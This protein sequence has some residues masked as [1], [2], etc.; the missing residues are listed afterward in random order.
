MVA[1]YVPPHQISDDD[2][3]HATDSVLCSEEQ[4]YLCHF[5][6]LGES[7]GLTVSENCQPGLYPPSCSGKQSPTTKLRLNAATDSGASTE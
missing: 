4:I 7:E 1:S 2:W 6:G 3:M 5:V